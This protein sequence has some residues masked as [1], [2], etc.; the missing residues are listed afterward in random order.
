MK[1][2]TERARLIFEALGRDGWLRTT[3]AIHGQGQARSCRVCLLQKSVGSLRRLPDVALSE[4]GWRIAPD[5]GR[6]NRT[7]G[8][9]PSC[10]QD[11]CARLPYSRARRRV[12]RAGLL[13]QRERTAATV[14][15][16]HKT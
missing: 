6:L 5:A 1:A 13:R 3:A 4:R 7:N 10:L 14:I 8:Y 16:N 12:G 15:N 11:R 2:V 9:L